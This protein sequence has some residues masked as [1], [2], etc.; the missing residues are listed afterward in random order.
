[1]NGS[2]AAR[3][4]DH[5]F[6]ISS[7]GGYFRYHRVLLHARDAWQTQTWVDAGDR[8]RI[9]VTDSACFHPNPNLTCSRLGN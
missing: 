6:R 1:M 2:D 8:G 9:G 7:I 3:L 5:H 4:S